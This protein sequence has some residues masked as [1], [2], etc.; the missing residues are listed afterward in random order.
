MEPINSISIDGEVVKIYP[1]KLTPNGL[2][3]A[4]FVLEHIS[5]QIEAEISRIVKCRLYCIIVNISD[6]QIQ[7]LEKSFVNVSG[8][9]SQN[10][11]AQIVLNVKQVI[12]KGSQKCHVKQ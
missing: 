4:T 6:E 9:L 12:D 5:N 2:P 7:L 3:V 8:F 11:K 1:T 10:S